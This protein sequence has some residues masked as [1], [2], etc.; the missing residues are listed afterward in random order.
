[1]TG[2]TD[3]TKGAAMK[4]P[5]ARGGLAGVLAIALGA[6]C[7]GASFTST[8]GGTGGGGAGTTMATTTSGTGGSACGD[9]QTDPVNCGGCGKPCDVGDVCQGGQCSCAGALKCNVCTQVTGVG[10]PLHCGACGT[11]CQDSQYCKDSNCVCR[12]GL[13]PCAGTCVDL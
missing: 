6:G 3:A 1:M 13:T 11:Q 9:T 12:P 5:I 4:G 2:S 8:T 10:D 7:V